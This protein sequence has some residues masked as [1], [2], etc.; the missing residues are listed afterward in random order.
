MRFHWD[1]VGS[2]GI[3]TVERGIHMGF[4]WCSVHML[5]DSMGSSWYSLIQI[6]ALRFVKGAVQDSCGIDYEMMGSAESIHVK[7]YLILH[8]IYG[9]I[10]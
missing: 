10:L 9:I 5:W 7:Y 4:P 8:D 3:T 6:L 2:R 1:R